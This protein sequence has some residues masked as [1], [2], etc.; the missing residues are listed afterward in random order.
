VNHNLDVMMSKEGDEVYSDVLQ[1]TS[2]REL[3]NELREDY[4][5]IILDNPPMNGH[6]SSLL[7]SQYSDSTV[8]IVNQRTTLSQDVYK[9]YKNIAENV[10]YPILS[11]LN[12][13]Y[14]DITQSRRK[15]NIKK[16][17]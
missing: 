13:V 17:A 7:V 14:D 10:D 4:D 12:F 2:F 8:M 5:L 6:M 11:I 16:S 15:Q 1:S 9:H 3:I